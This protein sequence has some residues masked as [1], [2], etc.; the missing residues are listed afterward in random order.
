MGEILVCYN[1]IMLRG[2]D[3][4][5]LEFNK[6]INVLGEYLMRVY[7]KLG[8]PEPVL[9]SNSFWVMIDELVNNWSVVYRQESEDF[10]HD[11]KIDRAVEGTLSS[12][13]KANVWKKSVAYPPSLYRMIKVFFPTLKLQDKKFIS[14]FISRYPNFNASNY[15]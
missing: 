15:T 10:I 12:M 13:N 9:T 3:L 5:S 2:A 7:V 6:Y 1:S 4:S 8:R 14:K 11:I